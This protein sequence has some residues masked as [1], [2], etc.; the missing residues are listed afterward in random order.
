MKKLLE[1]IRNYSRQFFAQTLI[2]FKRIK[3]IAVDIDEINQMIGEQ[4][5]QSFEL[6]TP[7]G[8]GELTI[9]EATLLI[10]DVGRHLKV[11]LLCNFSVNVKKTLIY[12]THLQLMLDTVADFRIDRKAIGAREVKVTELNL[13]SD[14]YS[15][16]KETNGLLKGLLPPS[17]SSLLNVTLSSTQ[18]ILG[19]KMLSP[20]TRY[21]S[22]YSSGSKQKILD[23][24]RN[25]IEDKVI[26][27]TESS[28]MEYRLNLS[29]FE[30]QL[31]AEFGEKI[32]VENGTLYFV[33]HS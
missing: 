2:R 25:D 19:S 24:H 17:I 23:Y 30:E 33:F 11:E 3:R 15:L 21:L 29:V 10:P 9:L 26:K 4:L 20:A 16:I 13:I 8:V 18:A 22:L 14:K 28:E 32:I 12:N 27:L 7:A 6:K 5:P 1:T 31:F